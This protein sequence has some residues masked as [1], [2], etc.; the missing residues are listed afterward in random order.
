[1]NP[2]GNSSGALG[3]HMLQQLIATLFEGTVLCATPGGM[4]DALTIH[5]SEAL[6]LLP[7]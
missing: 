5:P 3:K 1:M 6:V 7:A 2:K 4:V